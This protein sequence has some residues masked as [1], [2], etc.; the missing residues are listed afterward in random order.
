MNRLE[1]AVMIMLHGLL[2]MAYN[3]SAPVFAWLYESDRSK[4]IP[5]PSNDV[6]TTSATEL[7]KKIRSREVRKTI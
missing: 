3:I 7:A 5:P 1:F 6:I 4:R 2:R